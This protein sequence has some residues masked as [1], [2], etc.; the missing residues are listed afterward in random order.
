LLAG[1]GT[2]SLAAGV[3]GYLAASRGAVW[4]VEPLASLVPRERHVRF[5]VD[6]WAHNA[7][8]AAGFLGGLGLSAWAWRERCRRTRQAPA[9]PA[10]A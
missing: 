8:Y 9:E 10:G 2:A 5:L 3:A 4:L 7:A 1:M 6:L